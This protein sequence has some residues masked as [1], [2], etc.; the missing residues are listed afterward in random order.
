[1]ARRLFDVEHRVKDAPSRKSANAAEENI[2][3]YHILNHVFIGRFA[4]DERG[5]DSE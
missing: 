4:P 3:A 1:M 5:G 2:A